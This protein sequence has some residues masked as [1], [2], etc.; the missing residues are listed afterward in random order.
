MT[1]LLSVLLAAQDDATRVDELIRQLSDKS[2]RRRDAARAELEKNALPWRRLLE[3][4]APAVADEK[5]RE[6]LS[7]LAERAKKRD[8]EEMKAAAEELLA[9]DF[10]Q[11]M[12]T[13]SVLE[14]RLRTHLADRGFEPDAPALFALIM[15]LAPKLAGETLR[16]S[17][18]HSM[19]TLAPA[20]RRAEAVRTLLEWLKDESAIVRAACVDSLADLRETAAARTILELVHDPSPLVRARAMRAIAALGAP[21][22]LPDLAKLLRDED[23]P[24]RAAALENIFALDRRAAA[25]HARAALADEDPQVRHVA[26]RL[27]TRLRDYEAR[28]AV[29]KL[30]KDSEPTI[31]ADAIRFMTRLAIEDHVDEMCALS[32]DGDLNVLIRLAQALRLLRQRDRSAVLFDL[33]K[34]RST[35][36][37]IEAVRA[38]G[39]LEIA[40]FGRV[41]K[42]L[43]RDNNLRLA[44]AFALAR[45]KAK[46][47]LEFI[48]RLARDT[49]QDQA[50]RGIEALVE[51][52]APEAVPIMLENLKP[53]RGRAFYQ[54]LIGLARM[55]AKDSMEKVMAIGDRRPEVRSMVAL[56]LMG[57]GATDQAETLRKLARDQNMIYVRRMVSMAT[58]LKD[59]DGWM[60]VSR[61]ELD[62][63]AETVEE[64][65]AEIARQTGVKVSTQGVPENFLK[66]PTAVNYPVTVQEALAAVVGEGQFSVALEGG[67]LKILGPAAARDFI[68]SW[69]DSW[70]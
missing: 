39:A 32:R 36:V 15:H 27:A 47:H 1:L 63:D 60:K 51:M 21:E 2:S 49:D 48:V 31:R 42:D 17:A 62:P 14:D 33:L 34:V 68:S 12:R 45:L 70:K 22:L 8:P 61:R 10:S 24:L 43:Y 13:A 3:D 64:L 19:A 56:Y 28:E 59:P 35:D 65:M 38:M 11:L 4:K 69:L 55:G 7:G 18:A 23:P 9:S 16:S 29:A 44:T 54:S 6:Y 67:E 25:P 26:L 66:T 41:A 40:E 20:D 57:V 53:D 5:Q 46:D 50:A 58:Y 52:G 30:F 37:R